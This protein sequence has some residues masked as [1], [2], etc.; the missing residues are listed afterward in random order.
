MS[1]KNENEEIISSIIEIT[2]M[3]YA[4]FYDWV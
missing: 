2:T 1:I 4:L 3:F